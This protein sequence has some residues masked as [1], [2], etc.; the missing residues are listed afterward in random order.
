[1]N[2]EY[3]FPED[4]DLC[5]FGPWICPKYLD[6]ATEQ[7]LSKYLSNEWRARKAKGWGE[8]I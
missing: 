6:S 4:R 5:L 2:L 3:A 8:S 1:M 7:V